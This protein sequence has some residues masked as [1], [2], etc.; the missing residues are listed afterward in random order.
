MVGGIAS[1][2]RVD[3][4]TACEAFI[5]RQKRENRNRRT[6]YSDG[7]ALK[8]LCQFAGWKLPLVELTDT[9]DQRILRHHE[10]RWSAAHATQPGKEIS[11]LVR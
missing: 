4:Q 10:A 9:K 8:Y 6:I 1:G 7:Q 3:L 2:K 11:Q 5:E